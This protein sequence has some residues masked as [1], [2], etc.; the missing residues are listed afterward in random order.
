MSFLHFIHKHS[1]PG[2]KRE[3]GAGLMLTDIIIWWQLSLAYIIIYSQGFR[4]L[5]QKTQ[6]LSFT[7]LDTA[8]QGFVWFEIVWAMLSISKLLSW[9]VERL[10]WKNCIFLQLAFLYILRNFSSLQ[11]QL[12]R[13]PR[14]HF[15]LGT[16]R[17]SRSRSLWRIFSF[18]RI[19]PRC[20][21]IRL[22][23]SPSSN[24]LERAKNINGR[25]VSTL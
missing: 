6:N 2:T 16:T 24:I 5:T 22:A 8:I 4:A 20:D 15:L 12:S 18:L 11:L 23:T 19:I 9:L 7:I 1:P 17:F 10:N 13:I 21:W 3:F 14:S 25:A